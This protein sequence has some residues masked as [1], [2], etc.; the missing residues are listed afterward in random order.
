M[1]SNTEDLLPVISFNAKASADEQAEAPEFRRA[2]GRQGLHREAGAP[3]CRVVPA[4]AQVVVTGA[5]TEPGQRRC[6]TSSTAGRTAA[7]RA[8]ST[9]SASCAG[10]RRRSETAVKQMVG[11]RRF[12]DMEQ[13]G[14]VRVPKK[15]ISEPSFGFGRGGDREFVLPGNREYVAGD[16][17]P[18]P[19][20]AGSGGG[21]GSEAARATARTTSCS[22]CRAKSSCRSSSTTSSCRDLARTEIGHARTTEEHP[23]G[24]H[25]RLAC[26]RIS[27]SSARCG[28]RSR[29]GSRSP[30]AS[31]A[32]REA[33]RGGVR[34]G[35]RG[36][37]MR[38]EAAELHDELDRLLRRR[39]QAAVSRRTRPALPQPRL[40]AGADRARG[41]V[42]PDGRF[43][44]DGRGQEGPRQA[45]L[46]AAVPLPHPQVRARWT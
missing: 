11:E 3:A 33:H 9:A 34:G 13:G 27:P 26:R 40:A 39:E 15:D 18:R 4:R 36:R 1:F 2:H 7:A 37:T 32:R 29:G 17:I 8:R 14:E 35:R 6:S 38:S 45:L 22:R 42:L 23:R 43:G 10:T 19:E 30:A 12:A 46:H 21:D 20:G 25:A 5:K 16:R 24:L 44:V 41:D 28:S 31:R